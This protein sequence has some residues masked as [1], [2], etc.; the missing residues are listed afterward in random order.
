MTELLQNPV[1]LSLATGVIIVLG[2]SLIHHWS[3]VRRTAAEAELK[4]EMVRQ[5]MS[6]DDIC[7]VVSV[8]SSSGCGKRHRE[9][10]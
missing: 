7:R 1:F 4:L 9:Y 6:A 10:A 2:T 8:K 5:G 3:A